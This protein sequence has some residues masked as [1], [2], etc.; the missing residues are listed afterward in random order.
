MYI[1]LKDNTNSLADHINTSVLNKLCQ[2]FGWCSEFSTVM[3]FSERERVCVEFRI[4][5][6]LG[7]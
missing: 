2:L 5:F 6:Q 4:I 1:E 3:C 7:E